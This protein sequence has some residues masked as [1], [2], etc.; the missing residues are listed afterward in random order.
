MERKNVLWESEIDNCNQQLQ[1]ANSTINEQERLQKLKDSQY[2]V[3]MKAVRKKGL[4]QGAAGGTILTILL[5]L[6]LI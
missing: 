3:D 5:C 2:D 1:L 6:L 4:I